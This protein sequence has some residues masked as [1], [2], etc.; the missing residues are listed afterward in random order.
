[1][2]KISAAIYSD[3]RPVP[4]II[5]T[6]EIANVSGEGLDIAD[7]KVDAFTCDGRHSPERNQ[8]D[9]FIIKGY[10][11][12]QGFWNLVHQATAELTTRHP[13]TD[14]FDRNKI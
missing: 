14:H 11:R 12:R 8:R 10:D 3:N 2:L 6:M 4:V 1:M 13:T 7:Y 9:S 5:G